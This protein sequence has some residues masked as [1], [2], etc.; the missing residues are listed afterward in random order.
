MTSTPHN[1]LQDWKYCCSMTWLLR[2]LT[3]WMDG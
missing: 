2:R 1:P 3:G